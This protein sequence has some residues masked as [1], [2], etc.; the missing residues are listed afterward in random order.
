M[1][2]FWLKTAEA[3]QLNKLTLKRFKDIN[4]QLAYFLADKKKKASF[5]EAISKMYEAEDWRDMNADSVNVVQRE[6]FVKSLPYSVRAVFRNWILLMTSSFGSTA[7]PR[8]LF[9]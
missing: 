2:Q 3:I 7:M 8:Q 1:N 9:R 5:F 6:M 4:T